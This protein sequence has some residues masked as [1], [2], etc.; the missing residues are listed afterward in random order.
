M[1][2]KKIIILMMAGLVLFVSYSYNIFKNKT[3][4]AHYGYYIGDKKVEEM[5]TSDN[6]AFDH[7][8]CDKGASVT[9]D[10]KAWAPLVKNIVDEATKCT[11]Y[12]R[13]RTYGDVVS[14]CGASGKKAVECMLENAGVDGVNLAFDGDEQ[15][16]GDL[17]TSDNNLRYIGNNPS[18]YIDIG[19]VYESDTYRRMST[20]GGF[21]YFDTYEECMYSPYTTGECEKVHSKGEPILWRIVGVMNNV[22]LGYGDPG[23]YIK[24]VRAEE[25]GQY[26]WDSSLE[27]VNGGYGV[28]EWSQAD[29]YKLLNS[30]NAV[31]NDYIC[32]YEQV[33]YDRLEQ[34]CMH[35]NYNNSL[36]AFYK[37]GYC[38]IGENNYAMECRFSDIGIGSI[39]NY[40]ANV[41][42]HTGAVNL[43][44]PYSAKQV[45]DDERSEN[46]GNICV[47]ESLFGLTDKCDDGLERNTTV[48]DL[49]GL[50]YASDYAY[51]I[52]GD[53]SVLSNVSGAKFYEN[54]WLKAYGNAWLLSP[55]VDK[56]SN[57]LALTIYN[58]KLSTDR[59]SEAYDIYPAGYLNNN[60]RIVSGIGTKSDPFKIKY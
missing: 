38:T 46:V 51:S 34:V 39:S 42:W 49:F 56:I 32:F 7:G 18:N 20:L 2:K 10:K 11:L 53:R 43:G 37:N 9:W 47:D 5:P 8:V 60:L 36:Y 21:K 19:D 31:N 33:S 17:K 28:N 23:S 12:F 58:N 40:F 55:K 48:T 16:F 13:E 52:S 27:S 50:L 14:E 25:I 4:N 35:N 15:L 29:L 1:G 41:K 26:S 22:S 57:S 6:Y 24:I 3:Y 44:D 54:T 59:V 45:Y 30:G